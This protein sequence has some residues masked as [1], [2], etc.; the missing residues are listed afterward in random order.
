LDRGLFAVQGEV[1]MDLLWQFYARAWT[2]K[3]ARQCRAINRIINK[4]SAAHQA[5]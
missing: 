2:D 3:N 1:L 4:I 5:A